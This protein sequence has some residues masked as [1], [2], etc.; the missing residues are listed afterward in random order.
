[1]TYENSPRHVLARVTLPI[2]SD[3]NRR[4]NL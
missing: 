4:S 2:I 3:G 1:L